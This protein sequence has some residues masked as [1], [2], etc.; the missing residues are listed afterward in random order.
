MWQPHCCSAGAAMLLGRCA[1]KSGPYQQ[2]ENAAPS[3]SRLR[4]GGEPARLFF[5]MQR[6]ASGMSGNRHTPSLTHGVP[7]LPAPC[8][9]ATG[10]GPPARPSG[11]L[12][13]TPTTLVAGGGCGTVFSDLL[14]PHHSPHSDG[15]RA[16]PED[17]G[18][19][20]DLAA[21][22]LPLPSPTA[23]GVPGT[24]ETPAGD[25][26]GEEDSAGSAI[27]VRHR[28]PHPSRTI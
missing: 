17:D 15:G 10:G 20:P 3:S 8:P 28:G 18:A 11:V 25:P 16:S 2:A 19:H 27:P 7:A 21:L 12:P 9:A 6:C 26:A 14:P 23:S 24:P 5:C 13:G 4:G 22:R 1:S